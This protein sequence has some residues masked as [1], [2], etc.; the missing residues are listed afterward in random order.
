M[1]K[2]I[3]LVCFSFLL[4]GCVRVDQFKDYSTLI[5]DC[6]VDHVTTNEVSLG[7][8]YYVPKGVRKIHDYDYNQVFLI[9]GASVYLYVDIVSYFHKKEI[10][11]VKSSDKSVYQEIKHGKKKGYFELVEYDDSCFVRLYYNYSKIEFYTDK[12]N[13]NKMITLSSVILNSIRYNDMV[14]EKVLEGSF[15][16]FSEMN[17]EVEK[18]IDASSDFSQYLEE[19]VQK[20]KKEK[21]EELPDE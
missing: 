16:E 17:Y 5:D 18:P 8:R 4:V 21:K 10:K 13:L 2:K 6:L 14:I 7:Y 20:E 11:F 3:L 15:G 1:L 19:Y 9:D 12:D